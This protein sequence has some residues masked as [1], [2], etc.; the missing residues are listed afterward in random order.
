MYYEAKKQE[1]KIRCIMVD[2]KRR[3]ERRKVFYDKIVKILYLVFHLTNWTSNEFLFQRKKIQLSFCKY[4]V[5]NVK[6]T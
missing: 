1:K 2:Q 4:G 6:L 5:N 3:A